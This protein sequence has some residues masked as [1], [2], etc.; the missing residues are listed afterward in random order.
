[1]RSDPLPLLAALLSHIARLEAENARLR[2]APP[3]LATLLW[4][5]MGG[6]FLAAD[7]MA[8]AER[9]AE[10]ARSVGQAM[11]YLPCLLSEAGIDNTRKLGHWLGR[12]GFEI[13][14]QEGGKRIWVLNRT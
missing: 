7:A 6:P 3:P 1:M 10:A 9:Q 8:E 12:N 11:P 5:T 14:S 2:P 13:V 4:A